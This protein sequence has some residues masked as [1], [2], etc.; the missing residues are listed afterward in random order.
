MQHLIL[1]RETGQLIDIFDSY[2]LAYIELQK[3]EAD[4]KLEN[5]YIKDFYIIVENSFNIQFYLDGYIHNDD[6]DLTFQQALKYLDNPNN[7]FSR[8]KKTEIR[9]IRKSNKQ[10]VYNK[11]IK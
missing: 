6:T 10:I 7:A 3:Y 1:N 5:I 4:D 8:A 9:I 11:I 2:D